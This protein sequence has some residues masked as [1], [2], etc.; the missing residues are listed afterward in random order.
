MLLVLVKTKN[1]S[2]NSDSLPDKMKISM[3]FCLK[4]PSR[5]VYGLWTMN[6]NLMFNILIWQFISM[7]QFQFLE[8]FSLPLLRLHYKTQHEGRYFHFG[9]WKGWSL[10]Q[11][12]WEGIGEMS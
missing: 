2:F 5:R 12:Q 3:F 8:S 11:D 10:N 4:K 9:Q 6:S 7:L 1:L